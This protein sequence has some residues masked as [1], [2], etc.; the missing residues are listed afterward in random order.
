MDLV[1]LHTLP[2]LEMPIANPRPYWRYPVIQ[3]TQASLFVRFF[4]NPSV[5]ALL[6]SDTNKLLR[7]Q[8]LG[9]VAVKCLH[10][11]HSMWKALS[12]LQDVP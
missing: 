8:D 11:V 10:G 5:I 2:G 7:H 4:S 6:L 12:I 3:H 1:Q 9:R